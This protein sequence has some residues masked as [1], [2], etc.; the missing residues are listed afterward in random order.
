MEIGCYINIVPTPADIQDIQKSPL[1]IPV[2][3]Q[4]WILEP[5]FDFTQGGYGLIKY[6]ISVGGS[7]GRSE[8]A[9]APWSLQH[10]T[11]P[12]KTKARTIFL[13]DGARESVAPNRDLTRPYP[14][15][16]P[17]TTPAIFFSSNL[18][19]PTLL[20]NR[21]YRVVYHGIPCLATWPVQIPQNRKKRPK[22]R[23][24]P[25]SLKTK[26]V[27]IFLYHVVK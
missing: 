19:K 15:K 26:E 11:R 27:L 24:K 13:M 17:K 22:I 6:A 10:G 14:S 20:F 9:F 18:S 21:A 7:V 3:L 2:N 12:P 25:V 8:A 16:S 23:K 1:K 4:R 5:I